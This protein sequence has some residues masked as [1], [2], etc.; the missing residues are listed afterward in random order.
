MSSSQPRFGTE[1]RATRAEK[2]NPGF[3]TADTGYP[4]FAS[5]PGYLL[6]RFT[7]SDGRPLRVEFVG[8]AAFSWQESNARLLPGEPWDGS[9]ELFESP[10]LAAHP[11]DATLHSSGPLR[12]LRFNFNAWGCLDVL[13]VDFSAAP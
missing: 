11:P 12:H 8:V 1:R 10:L 5:A 6:A 9:C 4:E 7:S 2:F 13:C 3:S